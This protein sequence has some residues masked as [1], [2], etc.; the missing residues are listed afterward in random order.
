MSYL[1]WEQRALGTELC[2]SFGL[3]AWERGMK[4]TP[5][6]ELST[7]RLTEELGAGSSS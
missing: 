3:R 7:P 1:Y 2:L 4:V 6:G 5:I